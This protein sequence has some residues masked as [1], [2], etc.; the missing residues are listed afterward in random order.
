MAFRERDEVVRRL[1]Y[2]IGVWA[3]NT[4][5]EK[6]DKDWDMTTS[7]EQ[8]LAAIIRAALQKKAS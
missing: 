6:F 3:M 5:D 8:E 7:E 4:V 2:A 1:V